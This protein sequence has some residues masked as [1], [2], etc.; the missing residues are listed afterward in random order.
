MHPNEVIEEI[1]HIPTAWD[2]IALEVIKQSPKHSIVDWNLMWR[3][4]NP[5]WTS[6]GGLVC[7]L[8]DAAH[9]FLPTS[10]SGA[11]FAIED[12]ISLAACV[13][14]GGKSNVALAT[15]VHEALRWVPGK[16]PVPYA[17]ILKIS[18]CGLWAEN[19]IQKS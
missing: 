16:V 9:A 3:N 8:G 13:E 7:Q 15:K 14:L 10:G 12:G 17:N 18:A 6:P 1:A 11:T 19:G 4:P 5:Q 2:P